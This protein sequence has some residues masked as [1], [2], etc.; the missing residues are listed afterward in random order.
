MVLVW[1]FTCPD[2]LTASHLNRAVVSPGAVANDAEDRKSSKY[3]SL[4]ACY[5]FK[6]VVVETLG[7]LGEEA[8]AFFRDLGQRITAVIHCRSSRTSLVP[9]PDAESQRDITTYIYSNPAC[10]LVLYS[11]LRVLM[12]FLIYRHLYNIFANVCIEC[13]IFMIILW[14]IRDDLQAP[15]GDRN[16]PTVFYYRHFVLTN[17]YFHRR[18]PF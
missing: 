14:F 18:I 16:R 1:D 9:V 13:E 3:R 2:T 6:P 10:V 11:H 5:S 15:N 17:N 4:V 12:K 8:S 7:A